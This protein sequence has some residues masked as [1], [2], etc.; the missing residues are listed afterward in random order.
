MSTL[1]LTLR[2]FDV[3]CLLVFII[4]LSLN[5][6][7]CFKK[8]VNV[9][10]NFTLFRCC[11]LTGK[12]LARQVVQYLKKNMSTLILNLRCFNIVCLLV[13]IANSSETSDAI[14]KKCI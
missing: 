4:S 2:C 1:V 5:S 3:V 11:K 6:S 10:T 14:F 9:D 8:C 13:R 7:E 12:A